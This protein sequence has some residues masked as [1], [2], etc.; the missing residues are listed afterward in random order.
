MSTLGQRLK[1]LRNNKK[2]SQPEFAE[3]VGIEQSFLSK[4]ENDKSIPSN[5][6]FRSL[7]SALGIPIAEFMRPLVASKDQ[8]RLEQVPD[9]EQWI[10][11]Q[12]VNTSVKQRTLIY[13]AISLISFGS[14][15]FY[16][17]H[18][19]Y[20]FNERFYEY[21]SQGVI[22]ADEPLNIFTHW[23][24]YI[25][26]SNKEKREIKNQEML[27]RRVDDFILLDSYLGKSFIKDV[28][29]GKRLYFSIQAVP[30]FIEHSGNNWLEFI[31][32]FTALFGF[33]LS[34]LEPRLIRCQ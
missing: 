15:L 27:A 12:T 23:K 4:L 22:K 21:N 18:Q 34:V 32:I 31:G 7:L 24:D 33:T 28:S 29:G 6:T 8:T 9:I 2:L 26:D 25:V 3:Q 14:A 16:I 5:D 1:Q 13:L 19:N 11:Q 10:K 20:V 17:G 30:T